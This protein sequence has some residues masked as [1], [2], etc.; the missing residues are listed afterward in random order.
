[1]YA[2]QNKIMTVSE[3]SEKAHIL[4]EAIKGL[5]ST[6]ATETGYAAIVT[7]DMKII[8]ERQGN[9]LMDVSG[10]SLQLK[11]LLDIKWT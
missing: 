6:F 1:M 7:N 3:L 11:S 9:L 8:G 2:H 10:T 4:K 5:C